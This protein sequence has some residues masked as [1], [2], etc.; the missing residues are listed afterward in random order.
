MGYEEMLMFIIEQ[1]SD[2]FHKEPKNV[3][4]HKRGKW[5]TGPQVKEVFWQGIIY[6]SRYW[7]TCFYLDLTDGKERRK[8]VSCWGRG[9]YAKYGWSDLVVPIFWS[10]WVGSMLGGCS[11]CRMCQAWFVPGGIRDVYKQGR[12]HVPLCSNLS[13]WSRSEVASYLVSK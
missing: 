1:T 2:E 13:R 9:G 10:S 6:G 5:V 4:F 8:I 11:C 7:K 3:W 12:K